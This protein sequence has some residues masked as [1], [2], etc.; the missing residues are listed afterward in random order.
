MK[1]KFSII[2][3]D[4]FRE[5]RS[6]CMLTCMK[7]IPDILGL[8]KVS[9]NT[10]LPIVSSIGLIFPFHTYTNRVNTF[11]YALTLF[12]CFHDIYKHSLFFMCFQLDIFLA[13][14]TS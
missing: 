9:R 6:L 11:L 4:T 2:K 12:A 3:N 7:K 14:C 13:Q 10:N 1:T 5:F 8:G